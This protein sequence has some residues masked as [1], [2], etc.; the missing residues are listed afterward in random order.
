MNDE[1]KSLVVTAAILIF[2]NTFTYFSYKHYSKNKDSSLFVENT[3]MATL[4]CSYIYL[5]S[6]LISIFLKWVFEV[7]ALIELKLID[8]SVMKLVIDTLFKNMLL[9]IPLHVLI[10]ALSSFFNKSLLV[11]SKGKFSMYY[12]LFTSIASACI[13]LLFKDTSFDFSDESLIKYFLTFITCLSLIKINTPVD[14]SQSAPFVDRF[15][16]S[17]INIFLNFNWK[18]LYIL[19]PFALFGF[20]AFLVITGIS[21]DDTLKYSLFA[22]LF[23]LVCISIVLTFEYLKK[24]KNSD[25]LQS[26]IAVFEQILYSFLNP[27]VLK[28]F[29]KW[30]FYIIFYSIP[31]VAYLYF[32]KSDLDNFKEIYLNTFNESFRTILLYMYIIISLLQR[33]LSIDQN[34]IDKLM[35]SVILAS[36]LFSNTNIEKTN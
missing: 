7:L 17:F 1:H 36:L 35:T 4:I 19:A 8:D 13:G 33:Y 23:L 16:T 25:G 27:V 26:T 21:I 12:L 32:T 15:A 10:G 9:S 24:Q 5:Y 34:K 6:M 28:S 14:A 11:D 18:L 3:L 29:L 31:L 22:T 2:S 20:V 30:L